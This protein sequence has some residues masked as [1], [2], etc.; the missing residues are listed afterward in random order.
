MTLKPI[1]V[2]DFDGVIVDG[3]MEYWNSAREACYQ[4]LAKKE[5]FNQLPLEVPEQFRQLR[6]WV[7]DGWEMVLLA[8]ELVRKESSLKVSPIKFANHYQQNCHKALNAWGWDPKQ[9]QAALDDVRKQAISTD[10]EKWLRSHTAFSTVVERIQNLKNEGIDFA[11]LTTKSEE[12]TS[13]LLTYLDLYPN[14]LYG[15]ESGKKPNLLLTIAKDRPIKGFIEDRRRT[16]ETVLNT[17][18]LGLTPCYLANWGYLKPNDS[19][20][21]PK[22]IHLLKAENLMSPLADWS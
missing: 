17:P 21:L 18:G 20:D 11:V 16:L 7:K 14:L 12:F 8:A 6:P 19:Q 15:H 1:L 13:E 2:F 3:L 4:L 22:G 5:A 10:K 9:L